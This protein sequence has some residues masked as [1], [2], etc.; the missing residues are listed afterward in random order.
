MPASTR[1][2]RVGLVAGEHSGDILGAGLIRAI[3]ARIP[4]SEFFGVGGPR[5]R[6]AGFD[7]W[8]DSEAL[9]VMGL[10]EVLSHL[11]RL[12]KLRRQ[13]VTRFAERAPDAFVGIDAPDFNL[14]LAKRLRRRGLRTLQYV[15]PSVWAWREGRVKTIAKACDRVLCLLPF[16]VDFYD[17]HGVPATFVGHPLAQQIQPLDDVSGLR[18]QLRLKPSQPV[19]TLM[20]GSRLGEIQRLAPDFLRAAA[21][22]LETE[23]E[24][25]ILVPLASA[26]GEEAF[27]EF[28]KAY[29]FDGALRMTIGSSKDCMAASD[30]LLMASGTAALEG[31]L[32]AKPMVVAYRLAPSTYR[33][34]K[35]F[36][37][38]KLK[39]FS[40]PNLL[41]E[42][43]FVPEFVQGEV[44][45]EALAEALR[46]MLRQ[47]EERSAMLRA[48]SLVRDT[49]AVDADE[50]A[51][52]AVIETSGFIV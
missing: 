44:T 38:V 5:M 30:A 28:A 49:L 3:R 31:L 52:A 9:A 13:L 22:L 29:A 27:S 32:H 42:T 18:E 15:S 19:L 21:R 2:F 16:E 35:L 12:L 37:L 11:P 45:G 25:Q 20:P 26:R 17:R 43:P 24:L 34:V 4:D 33:I 51:A 39:H 23:P 50:R 7:C 1:A 40:L 36:N 8:E 10:T 41:T 46:P 14:G 6:E 48:F 47:G